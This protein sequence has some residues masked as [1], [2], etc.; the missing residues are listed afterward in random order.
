[1]KP[2][3]V[4]T[5][6][7]SNG[8]AEIQRLT[9]VVRTLEEECKRLRN[10]LAVAEAERKLYRTAFYDNVRAEAMRELGDVDMPA[11]QKMSAGPVEI[12]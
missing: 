8:N 4:S 12:I 2:S 11:L 1:M 7:Q 6:V 3:Q 9:D 5:S 10:E